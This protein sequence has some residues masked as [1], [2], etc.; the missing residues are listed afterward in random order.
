ML[1]KIN[2]ILSLVCV[3]LLMDHAIFHAVWMLS[4]GNVEKSTTVT[5]WVMF[6][7]MFVHAG[8]SISFAITGHKGA[9]VKEGKEYPKLNLETMIQRMGGMLLI[10]FTILHVAGT[11]GILQPPPL[12]HA[13]LPPIFFTFAM[14]HVFVS[15]SKAFITLGIGNSKSVK[16]IDI[17][18]KVLCVVT[19][20]AAVV[21]FYLF[22]C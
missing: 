16:V 14:A 5:S 20:I 9:T 7:L 11:V 18:F 17:V 22:V 10:I 19:L 13:I 4:M 8:I 12:V 1:R 6:G 15:T 21:G 3:F 2:A